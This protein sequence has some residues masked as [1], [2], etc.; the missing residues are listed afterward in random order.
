MDSNPGL[1]GN[2]IQ[3]SILKSSKYRHKWENRYIVIN[4]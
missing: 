2:F 1:G 3:G 4:N